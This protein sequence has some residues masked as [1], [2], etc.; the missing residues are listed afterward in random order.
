MLIGILNSESYCHLGIKGSRVL[1]REIFSGIKEQTINAGFNG[2]AGQ[3]VCDSP[4]G[5]SHAPADEFPPAG[6]LMLKDYWYA[7]R[8]AA[9]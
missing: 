2:L 3:Q 6:S 9:A 5:V 7:R 8:R 1:G 4:I